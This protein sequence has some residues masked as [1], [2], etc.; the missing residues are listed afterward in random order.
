MSEPLS[1]A[2]AALL[3]ELPEPQ[4]REPQEEP[5]PGGPDRAVPGYRSPTFREEVA[6][7]L[8][9]QG[10]LSGTRT[11]DTDFAH[12]GTG[13]PPTTGTPGTVT[14]RPSTPSPR[15]STADPSPRPST[16]SSLAPVNPVNFSS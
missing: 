16:S 10:P 11:P 8:E 13:T 1:M 7:E 4:Q 5:G 9:K 2:E 15:P 12:S 3:A 14:P 6:A